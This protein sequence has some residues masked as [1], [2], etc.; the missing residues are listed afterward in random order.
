[1]PGPGGL[2]QRSGACFMILSDGHVRPLS[3]VLLTFSIY[4]CA[5]VSDGSC[6][7]DRAVAVGRKQPSFVLTA[8]H[9]RCLDAYYKG[10][11][12]RIGFRPGSSRPAL[13]VCADRLYVNG[14]ILVWERD[15]RRSRRVRVCRIER[16]RR[17]KVR[18]GSGWCDARDASKDRIHARSLRAR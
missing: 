10:S 16:L 5:V 8:F 4:F 17:G 2:G 1:M 7:S 13:W 18:C 15:K 11:R 12:I 3:C 6:R 14:Y 9:I